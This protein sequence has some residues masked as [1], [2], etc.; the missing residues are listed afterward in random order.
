MAT[1]LEVDPLRNHRRE[2]R[3]YLISAFQKAFARTEEI[4]NLI[5]PEAYHEQPI[6]LRHPIIFYEGHL[7][8]FIW[9]P[10]FRRALGE[11][12][13][14]PH[15]DTLFERGIDPANE[16]AA[17]AASIHQWPPREEIRNYK[18]N[19]HERLFEFID[20][21]DFEHPVHPLLRDAELL[22]LILE[23]ELMHQETL[24]YILH[25]LPYK[26]KIPP[27]PLPHVPDVIP[28][29]PEM[30]TI[31]AGKAVLGMQAGEFDF[32]W[33][34]E[35]PSL[36]V[37]VEAFSI[38][39][40]NV[41]NGQFLEFME[42][43]GYDNPAFWSEEQWAW[44]QETGKIHPFFWK[45]TD[46]GWML[47]DFFREIPLPLSWPVYVTHAEASAYARFAGKRLPT[48]AEWH[49]AAFG[50]T[51]SRYPWGN[52]EPAGAHGNFDFHNWS[53]VPVGSY[54][55]G[56]SPFGV[57][58]LTGNGWEWTFTPFAPF[59]GF[60]ASEGYPQYSA[61]F[62]DGRHYVMKGAS[63]FT[64]ARLLRRSFRNWY[65]WHYP[66]MYATFRCVKN[67]F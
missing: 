64:D 57:H 27:H 62:F 23:H 67:Q 8:A 16:K 51:L 56:A 48:E 39:V 19:I 47:R 6:P 43:G 45:R 13:L 36:T 40:Y 31:P 52:E 65:Y 61:D 15:F 46:G 11:K 26:M 30:I 60:Q 34:N 9:N 54:P 35:H 20:T 5:T 12:S 22:Y 17:K 2:H 38:D 49:R 4:F 29:M 41:T 59:P 18:R 42:A 33:D 3:D 14:H 58:D 25:Q 10:L 63:C 37:N 50:D 53:P 32:V 24:L 44:R 1:R 55:H 7:P 21:A 28:P 66:Y